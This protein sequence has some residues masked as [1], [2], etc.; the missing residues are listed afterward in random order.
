MPPQQRGIE[1]VPVC[2][3]LNIAVSLSNTTYG[4]V[5]V[6]G[7]RAVDG[8]TVFSLHTPA[9]GLSSPQSDL[10]SSRAWAVCGC[11]Y[12]QCRRLSAW[13]TVLDVLVSLI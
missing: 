12:S 10:F 6:Q 7:K 4:P 5:W 13:I 8:N 1:F 3:V 2:P 11:D 9:E